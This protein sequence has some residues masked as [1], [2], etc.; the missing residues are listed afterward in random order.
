MASLQIYVTQKEVDALNELKS[1]LTASELSS[2]PRR[3][4]ASQNNELIVYTY[5]EDNK[6]KEVLYGI[7]ALRELRLVLNLCGWIAADKLGL[8]EKLSSFATLI[9]KI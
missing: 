6:V 7:D 5:D 1:A 4:M 8:R 9:K 3:F 2:Y